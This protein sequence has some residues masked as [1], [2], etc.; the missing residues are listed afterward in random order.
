M[1]GFW[2]TMSRGGERV[3]KVKGICLFVKNVDFPIA[4]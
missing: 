2:E 1:S 4:E 3:K